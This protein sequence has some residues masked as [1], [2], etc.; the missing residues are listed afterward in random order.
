MARMNLIAVDDDLVGLFRHPSALELE[1]VQVLCDGQKTHR[2]STLGLAQEC[3]AVGRIRAFDD[4]VR[5]LCDLVDI[6]LL[7]TYSRQE[8]KVEHRI[9]FGID[10]SRIDEGRRRYLKA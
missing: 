10:I 9:L 6:F 1:L 5:A 7:K 3:R 8:L 4:A 2:V